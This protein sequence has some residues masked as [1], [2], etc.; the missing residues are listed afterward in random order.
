MAK[1]EKI[2]KALFGDLDL[3]Q[4]KFAK[5]PNKKLTMQM[6]VGESKKA[7]Y[8]PILEE[9]GFGDLIPKADSQ[10]KNDFAKTILS[11]E[12][13]VGR[14]DLPT[15]LDSKITGMIRG[16]ESEANIQKMID[17][18]ASKNI[19][20]LET[21]WNTVNLGIPDKKLKFNTTITGK[22][23]RKHTAFDVEA[24]KFG[25]TIQCSAVNYEL[26]RIVVGYYSEET[27][28]EHYK[29]ENG[30]YY[31]LLGTDNLWQAVLLADYESLMACNLISSLEQGSIEVLSIYKQLKP[32]LLE[33]FIIDT[34]YLLKLLDNREKGI[35]TCHNNRYDINQLNANYKF[36]GIKKKRGQRRKITIINHKKR[37]SLKV[38]HNY[39][40]VYSI[41]LGNT[42]I[43]YRFNA[44]CNT[45]YSFNG[46]A[47]ITLAPIQ[48]QQYSLVDGIDTLNLAFAGQFPEKSL[49]AL[50]KGL[51]YEKSKIEDEKIFN[52]EDIKI[53]NGKITEKVRYNL[54]D[55]FATLAVYSMLSFHFDLE[56]LG[57]LQ[58]IDLTGTK[59][60][61]KPFAGSIISPATISK[62][63]LQTLLVAR[64]G[65]SIKEIE[66]NFQ[67]IRQYLA[68][69]K[70]TY[71]GGRT[72][73]L[74]F[75]LI[76][77]VSSANSVLDL[78]IKY[79]DFES[80]YPNAARL[81][82]GERQ[83]IEAAKGKLHEFLDFDKESAWNDFWETVAYT[84]ETKRTLTP[85]GE[86]FCEKILGNVR[87]KLKKGSLMIRMK[88]AGRLQDKIIRGTPNTTVK[89]TF[90][91]LLASVEREILENDLSIRSLKKRIKFLET[92]RLLLGET[93]K[94]GD[95]FF[96][97]TIVQRREVKS[98][99]EIVK[100]LLESKRSHTGDQ[101]SLPKLKDY[102]QD[103]MLDGYTK[104]ESLT[105][106]LAGLNKILKHL[107]EVRP[108]LLTTEKLPQDLDFKALHSI[109]L[110][111]ADKIYFTPETHKLL[112]FLKTKYKATEQLLKYVLNSAYGVSAEGIAPDKDFVGKYQVPSVACLITACSR[113]LT[114]SAELL[115]RIND[116]LPLY[117]DTD[118]LV[119]RALAKLH[120]MIF[121]YFKKTI[122]LRE[123]R[124]YGEIVKFYGNG[125]KKYGLQNKE[126]EIFFK[127]HG[128]GA[129]R[130]TE[131]FYKKLYE[132][133]MNTSLTN[134]E[135][136][137][138]A[139][140]FHQIQQ[141]ITYRKSNDGKIKKM[142]GILKN[143]KILRE[144]DYKEKNTDLHLFVYKLE[145]DYLIINTKSLNKGMFGYYLQIDRKSNS[146]LTIAIFAPCDFEKIL[147]FII[148]KEK[149][150]NMFKVLRKSKEKLL[151]DYFRAE[152][153]FESMTDK[154]DELPE[155]EI[156]IKIKE[157]VKLWQKFMK[158][159]QF[160][161][162]RFHR[163]K[164]ELSGENYSLMV[165][166]DHKKII[167]HEPIK[168]YINRE[169]FD[170]D[171]FD[172]IY[173]TRFPALDFAANLKSS[174][175]RYYSMVIE[176]LS[177]HASIIFAKTH[178]SQSKFRDFR[179]KVYNN[180][181]SHKQLP[182]P[183]G[184]KHGTNVLVPLKLTLKLSKDTMKIPEKDIVLIFDEVA[185]N[186]LINKGVIELMGDVYYVR[187]RHPYI[188]ALRQSYKHEWFETK[189]LNRKW[190]ISIEN[191]KSLEYNA[192]LSIKITVGLD[193]TFLASLRL[194]PS[195]KNL[196]NLDLFN[197]NLKELDEGAYIGIRILKRIFNEN[198]D[199][200]IQRDKAEKENKETT[201][202]FYDQQRATH[203]EDLKEASK[204]Y[205]AYK[206]AYLTIAHKIVSK[207]MS[208]LSSKLGIVASAV[209]IKTHSD[210]ENLIP[211]LRAIQL[212]SIHKKYEACP[213][214]SE[215]LKKME[216]LS[217]T[218]N[219]FSIGF[220]INDY[221]HKT[222][223]SIYGKTY[224]QYLSKLK[225][226]M[227][228]NNLKELPAKQLVKLRHLKEVEVQ[229]HIMRVEITIRGWENIHTR[230][231][232]IHLARMVKWIKDRD[233]DFYFKEQNTMKD[234]EKC[235][236]ELIFLTESKSS[237][238][239]KKYRR[240][241]E[242]IEKK[243]DEKKITEKTAVLKSKK[244]ELT[245]YCEN[246]HITYEPKTRAEELEEWKER[247][248]M[249]LEK[250]QNEFYQALADL[251]NT[252]P[253]DEE[254]KKK[255]ATPE[256]CKEVEEMFP[257]RWKD[258][259]P[260][261]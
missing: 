213:T 86:H 233:K 212:K 34:D 211:H 123:E 153:A 136:L 189:W 119:A 160:D 89:T 156:L 135:I 127:V 39:E 204:P 81:I 185:R 169:N 254:L 111:L 207:K 187:K 256:E 149:D 250:I 164:V 1:S 236:R 104:K 178:Y 48:T 117:T 217:I 230:Q 114:Y 37:E 184:G 231:F 182:C 41:G 95:E 137:K 10:F 177:R 139:M 54:M 35:W 74:I 56:E 246:C 255:F 98:S 85:L 82:Q 237:K 196:H 229:S 53:E 13:K 172:Y 94:F 80:Q 176:N 70:D 199:T 69:F 238:L 140:P 62:F 59:D 73:G 30:W 259:P 96:T 166:R 47:Q 64:T 14:I 76:E 239:A 188:K 84:V 210:I 260:D 193:R 171:G 22:Y 146:T 68:N 222:T 228:A 150:S 159:L 248:A 5:E 124:K 36:T 183:K 174:E 99:L 134:A 147:K 219:R 60:W 163:R 122:P 105:L 241:L 180:E 143:G 120:K 190:S 121:R 218:S 72:E 191:R 88:S 97:Q 242:H 24:D 61:H 106:I 200:Y 155:S 51:A 165:P 261:D 226:V 66:S 78:L 112:D 102:L 220:N 103:L 221:K 113:Y 116:G 168:E 245:K 52:I 93:P 50:S 58:E 208:Y 55:C 247:S 79:P 131:E 179:Q 205:E 46:Y 151:E 216:E 152:Q 29:T 203:L 235:G 33:N 4:I 118:S 249:E 115:Y 21:D 77:T 2:Q 181:I 49:E 251:K 243:L 100:I 110:M 173:S 132:L 209:N 170:C 206:L 109:A 40:D 214:E 63:D 201:L 65:L 145:Q 215:R 195:S 11:A 142:L 107:K 252:H 19:K 234:C 128:T 244:L 44:Q 197:T 67:L 130:E 20:S 175:N 257:E 12:K 38:R 75:G 7:E 144:H 23:T 154:L 148:N 141:N 194:N 32:K 138:E 87:F 17:Y 157:K 8:D 125:K 92:E 126:G 161:A 108:E 129:Y 31:Y 202:T 162:N 83:I 71:Y 91:D 42:L 57:K 224:Y 9:R 101:V 43:G 45:R 16:K 26:K 167:S 90:F 25:H 223:L 253:I 227:N 192:M 15:L 232:Y 258:P 6:L 27:K 225:R 198:L 186:H 240:K 18:I 158:F 3:S 28:L 133:K